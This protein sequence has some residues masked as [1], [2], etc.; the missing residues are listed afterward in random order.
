MALEGFEAA[1]AILPPS[2]FRT[3]HGIR[4]GIICCNGIVQCYIK[5]EKDLEMEELDYLSELL[6]KFVVY[7]NTVCINDDTIN[8]CQLLA[9]IYKLRLQ[10]Q[11]TGLSGTDEEVAEMVA[12]MR[13]LQNITQGLKKSSVATPEITR[14]CEGYM[15]DAKLSFDTLLISLMPKNEEAADMDE[16]LDEAEAREQRYML[17]DDYVKSMINQ[18]QLDRQEAEFIA[19][20][21]ED[22]ERLENELREAGFDATVA[23]ASVSLCVAVHSKHTHDMNFLCLNNISPNI[24][25]SL[26][27][28]H[29]LRRLMLRLPNELQQVVH[30]LKQETLVHN[31]VTLLLDWM[32]T[33]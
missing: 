18:K 25:L 28:Q 26:N 12:T 20:S 4:C 24:S 19:I 10:F 9:F 29:Y 5:R 30:V 31:Q 2:V 22:R 27:H 1:L 11:A 14:R 13:S 33:L 3:P 16:E 32:A 21:D 8:S 6:E 17:F 23:V 15:A 7:K